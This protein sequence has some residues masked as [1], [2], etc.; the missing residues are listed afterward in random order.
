MKVFKN[1]E[2]FIISNIGGTYLFEIGSG[3][4]YTNNNTLEFIEGQFRELISHYFIDWD[5]VY[6]YASD[7]V[8]SEYISYIDKFVLDLKSDDVLFSEFWVKFIIDSGR[9]DAQYTIKSSDYNYLIDRNVGLLSSKLESE[10]NDY[11]NL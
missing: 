7:D 1:Y 4:V 6:N 5:F 9:Y 10:F 3:C 8:R 2:D 11:L